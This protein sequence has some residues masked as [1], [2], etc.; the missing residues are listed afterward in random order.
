MEACLYCLVSNHILPIK[1]HSSH[2]IMKNVN[3]QRL[4]YG[5]LLR[6]SFSL[7]PQS[8]KA[9]GDAAS[10][11]KLQGMMLLNSVEQ[12]LKHRELVLYATLN[13]TVDGR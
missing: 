3:I 2:P 10:R 11:G 1:E 12:N 9:W 4:F 8:D 7:H 6:F 5:T 13:F